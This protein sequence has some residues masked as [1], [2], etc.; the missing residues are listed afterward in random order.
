MAKESKVDELFSKAKKDEGW[1]K[2]AH[3]RKAKRHWLDR[4]YEK[5][6]RS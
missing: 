1:P 5:Q 3:R 2:K 6:L 4:S